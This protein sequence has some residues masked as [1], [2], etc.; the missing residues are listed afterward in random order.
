LFTHQFSGAG[1]G[2]ML[3]APLAELLEKIGSVQV[4]KV[5]TVVVVVLAGTVVAVVVVVGATV[6]GATVVVVGATV[7][8]LDEDV[9]VGFAAQDRTMLWVA[10]ALVDSRFG[11]VAVT[12]S[13]ADMDRVPPLSVAA[14]ADPPPVNARTAVATAACRHRVMSHRQPNEKLKLAHGHATPPASMNPLG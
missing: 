4:P 13:P 12:V 7:V 8:V 5:G 1:E 3:I 9:V 14:T 6:V 2:S 10:L 11:Q